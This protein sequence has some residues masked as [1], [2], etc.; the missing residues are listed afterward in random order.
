MLCKYR[1]RKDSRMQCDDLWHLGSAKLVLLHNV[2][3][4]IRQNDVATCGIMP[5]VSNM[6][7]FGIFEI[8]QS[9]HKS[10]YQSI[11][12]NSNELERMSKICTSPICNILVKNKTM[13]HNDTIITPL[14]LIFCWND[15]ILCRWLSFVS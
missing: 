13:V 3:K 12:K 7:C 9:G 2:P 8:N 1:E 10:P 11:P 5:R 15:K 4:P 6:V 14:L